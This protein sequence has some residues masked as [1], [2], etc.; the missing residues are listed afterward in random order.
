MNIE[1]HS[2]LNTI[3]IGASIWHDVR[4]KRGF[5]FVIV[6]QAEAQEAVSTIDDAEADASRDAQHFVVGKNDVRCWEARLYI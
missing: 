2:T 5:S 6:K 1:M 4:R 3:W